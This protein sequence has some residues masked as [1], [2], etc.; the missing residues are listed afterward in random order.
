MTKKRLDQ[1]VIEQG[2]AQSRERA[3]RLIL[4]GNVSVDGRVSDKP[5]VLFPAH[6][7][8]SLLREADQYVSRGGDK[9]AGALDAFSLEVTG[10]VCLDVGASTGGFSDCLLQR[11][12][13]RVYAVDVGYGQLAWKLRTDPRVRVIERANIRHLPESA[14][15]EPVDIVTVDVSFISLKIVVPAVFKFMKADASLVVL[16]KPQFE[17]GRSQVGKGG[18]VRDPG[19]HESVLRDLS[20]FFSGQGLSHKATAVSPLLGPKGNREFFMHL[21]LASSG[22]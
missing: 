19:L 12:A 3:K 7:R 9:L 8:I 21:D 13:A 16:V 18:V 10:C 6:A 4:S 5:G 2:L 11:G 15:P 14:L 20:G 17:V 1:L 22:S